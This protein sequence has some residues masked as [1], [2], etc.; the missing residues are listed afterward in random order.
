MQR[1]G[2]AAG[3]VPRDFG[4]AMPQAPRLVDPTEQQTSAA[5]RAVRPAAMDNA[6][7]RRLMLEK[8]LSLS[9]P[10]QRLTRLT[11]LRQNPCGGGNCPRKMDSDIACPQHRI[12]VLDPGVRVRPIAF[13]QMKHAG[14]EVGPT[15]GEHV[16]L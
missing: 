2:S 10:V 16:L 4:C 13:Y 9:N 1:I 6:S 5:Q 14:S 12:P 3:L 11:D 15:D 8:L 7:L